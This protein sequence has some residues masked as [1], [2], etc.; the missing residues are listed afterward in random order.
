MTSIKDITNRL[1]RGWNTWNTTSVTSFVNLPSGFAI[2]LGLKEFRNGNVL[3]DPL[4]GFLDETDPHVHPGAHAYDGSYTSQRLDWRDIDITIETA[5]DGDDYL[6]LITPHA[7]QKKPALL[8]VESAMLWNRPG[9]LSRDKSTIT[10]ELPEGEDVTV[11]ATA[12]HV[13][14]AWVQCRTPYLALSTES[15]IG[16]STG[17]KRSSEEIRKL[18][19]GQRETHEAHAAAFGAK[20]EAYAAMQSCMAWDT[21]YDPANNRVVTPVSRNW[22]THGGGYQMFCWDTYFGAMMAAIDCPDLAFSNAVAI[23]RDRVERGFVPNCAHASFQSHDRSQPPVGSMMCL[24]IYRLHP[25]RWFLETVYDDLLTWNRWWMDNRITDGLLCWGSNAY[26]PVVGNTWEANGV[27]DR[28]G[29][30]LESGLD[31]SPMYDDIP[32]DKSTN[33]LMLQD[34]GLTGLYI[35]DC[36]ALAKIATILGKDADA[37]ELQQR[38]DTL[39]QECQRLWDEDL[40]L[41]LNRRTDTGAFSK[42]ISP[43]NF[44]PLIGRVATQAQAERM[45]SEHLT[46]PEEFW[47]EWVLPS[48]ARNDPAYPDNTYWRGRIWAPMNY[49]VYLG[50]T[51]YDLP[52]VRKELAAKSEALI[53]KEWRDH[54][55]VHENYNAN[56]G[57]GCD[58][59]N[60]DRFYHWG[61]LLGLMSIVD[62]ADDIVGQAGTIQQDRQGSGRKAGIEAV[63]S[64]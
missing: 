47:G 29:A 43:T 16:L 9:R 52:A 22:S 12:P 18:I 38:A 60:S 7:N 53:L 48:I 26:E 50:L 36:D 27:H 54:S 17:R 25:E 13:D 15:V 35:G 5:A 44:Y 4:I 51:N 49:L 30:A 21:I 56:T 1:A 11:H 20:A 2:E 24:E 28:F 34:A 59:G 62:A 37:A 19:D 58:V 46:N 33:Q 63:R 14:D 6:F 57:E 64:M 45:V 8:I 61:G 42:R 31:N 23:T 41:F 10:C 39:R 3:K 32:F 55:H 40:G